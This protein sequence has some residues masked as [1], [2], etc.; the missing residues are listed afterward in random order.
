LKFFL[1][2]QFNASYIIQHLKMTINVPIFRF[3][4]SEEFNKELG[5]FSKLH[6]CEDRIDFKENWQEWMIEN[7][8][9]INEER[10]RLINLGYDG[11]I[12][13]KMYKSV[14]YYFRK[15]PLRHEPLQRCAR[16]AVSKDLLRQIDDHIKHNN[17][18]ETYTPQI[19]YEEFSNE[20][21]EL[22]KTEIQQLDM[23]DNDFM[24]NKIKKTYKNRFYVMIRQNKQKQNKQKQNKT[25]K[26]KKEIEEIEEIEESEK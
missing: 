11:D 8:H 5:Y 19:A 22:I 26:N 14:R 24:Q 23:D 7:D 9:L 20:Y 15:K 6:K 4:F 2:L 18:N 25:K 1:N 21:S 17:F 12:E 3:N 10:K 16:I 13:D